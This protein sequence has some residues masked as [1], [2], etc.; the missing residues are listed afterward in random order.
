MEPAATCRNA[1]VGI[2]VI[3]HGTDDGA[4]AE[5]TDLNGRMGGL[6]AI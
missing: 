2:P 4:P 6:V 1:I 5:V 3:A